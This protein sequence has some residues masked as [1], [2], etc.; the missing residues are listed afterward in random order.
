MTIQAVVDF[1]AGRHDQVAARIEADMKAASLAMDFER[2]AVFRDRLEALRTCSSGNSQSGVMGAVDIIGMARDEH[3]VNVQVFLTRD[4]ILSDRRSFTL[5]NVE[6]VGDDEVL[7]RFVGEYYS[8]G[9]GGAPGGDRAAAV[10]SVWSALA[11]FLEGL[12]GTEVNVAH[13]RTRRQAPA[14]GAG[15]T[16]RGCSPWSTTGCAPNAPASTGTAR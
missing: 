8:D 3:G 15:P 6:G 10:G 9:A 1:L 13:R 7:E 11:T 5:V 2:A 14:A 4:G 12:R 16:Q